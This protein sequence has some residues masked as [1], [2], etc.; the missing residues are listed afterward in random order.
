MCEQRETLEVG[1]GIQ[2]LTAFR[3][4]G[5]DD[6]VTLLPGTQQIGREPSTQHN[7]THGMP[8]WWGCG[9]CRHWD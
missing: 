8:W 4:R 5:L 3:A 7:G 1:I 9:L 6:P 2:T